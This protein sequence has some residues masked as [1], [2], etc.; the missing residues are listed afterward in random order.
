MIKASRFE[1]ATTDFLQKIPPPHPRKQQHTTRMILGITSRYLVRD[2]RD[3]NA[4][5]L[6]AATRT[7]RHW[8]SEASI[9]A[10]TFS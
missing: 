7:L 3:L 10:T 4:V 8:T 2:E 1:T 5:R 9:P 6:A